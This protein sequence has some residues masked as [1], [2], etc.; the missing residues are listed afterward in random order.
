MKILFTGGGTGGHFYPIIAV[1]EAISTIVLKERLVPPKLYY[2]APDPYDESLLKELGIEFYFASA[3]KIRR[4]ASILN[5]FDVF[6]T[7]AGIIKSIFL[8]YR[9][10][11]DI[12]F[13]KGGYSSFPVTVAAKFLGIPVFVHESDSKPGRANL[14]AGKFAVRV[15]VS[16]P[17]AAQYF[18]TDTVA[19]TGNP[20]RR[21]IANPQKS[22]AYEFLK[23]EPNIPVVLILG[24]SSGSLKINDTLLATLPQL[25]P[26]YQIIHQTGEKHFESMEKTARVVLE[27]DVHAGR[28]HPFAYLNALAMKMAAGVADLVISRAGSTI[29]E[30]AVWGTPSIIIPIPEEVSHDQRGNAY[31]YARSG[32]AVVM[33]EKNLGPNLL[34]TEI[35]RLMDSPADRE[36][37]KKAAQS[38]ARPDAAEK[39]AKELIQIALSHEKL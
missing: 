36:E 22:G 4:Y 28:Y 29:F 16:F 30:I 7:F 31:T 12:I 3:G 19:L 39:I 6:K 2:V 8:L 32:A 38:F 23:L 37:M 1:A 35:K 25:V 20:I 13:S 10:F 21:D 34:A 15:A 26:H 33:E 11:P 14:W 18:P 9:I 5:V 27:G 17:E 24:G